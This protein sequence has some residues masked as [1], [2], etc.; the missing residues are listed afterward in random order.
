MTRG[1]TVCCA[2]PENMKKTLAPSTAMPPR[3][4]LRATLAS[5]S[6]T[7]RSESPSVT[8]PEDLAI[9][10][11]MEARRHDQP[12]RAAP[13]TDPAADGARV[14]LRL[15]LDLTECEKYTHDR[16]SRQREA[17]KPAATRRDGEEPRHERDDGERMHA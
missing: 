15:A 10:G 9:V 4:A 6:L 12:K 14:H 1:R 16:A 13:H 17:E 7:G 11:E 2:R 8:V 5:G 3:P